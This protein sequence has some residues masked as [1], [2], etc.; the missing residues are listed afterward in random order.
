MAGNL[1][2]VNNVNENDLE[3][4]VTIAAKHTGCKH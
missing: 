2:F 3:L 1:V 4:Q